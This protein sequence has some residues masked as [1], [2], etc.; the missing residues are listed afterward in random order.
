MNEKKIDHF[1]KQIVER[2]FLSAAEAC[3]RI[4]HFGLVGRRLKSESGSFFSDIADSQAHDDLI[5]FAIA[6]RRLSDIGGFTKQ[7]KKQKISK[8]TAIQLSPSKWQI[9]KIEET[10]DLY[11]LLDCLIHSSIFEVVSDDFHLKAI[12]GK[13]SKEFLEIY[14]EA[15][16]ISEFQPALVIATDRK[17]AFMCNVEEVAQ[18]AMDFL[19]HVS[20]DL[21]EHGIWL[22][23]DAIN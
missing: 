6:A 3:V 18:K 14:K 8:S 21:S 15:R 9:V 13:L 19:D 23:N 5:D 1:A 10:I 2:S 17:P 16:F 12:L 4:G 11:A 22:G 20:D 7:A